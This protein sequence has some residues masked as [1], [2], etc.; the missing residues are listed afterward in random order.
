MAP[1]SAS[2]EDRTV[3]ADFE[4]FA[5][6]LASFDHEAPASCLCLSRRA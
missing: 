3:R 5:V 2:E 6:A 1:H 4:A